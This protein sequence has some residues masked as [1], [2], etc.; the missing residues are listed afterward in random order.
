MKTSLSILSLS[1]HDSCN[2]SAPYAKASAA[3]KCMDIINLSRKLANPLLTPPLSMT[4]QTNVFLSKIPRCHAICFWPLFLL[5]LSKYITQ[6][7]FLGVGCIKSVSQDRLWLTSRR[8][9]YGIF[10]TQ[11]HQSPTTYDRHTSVKWYMWTK[12]SKRNFYVYLIN[13]NVTKWKS[14]ISSSRRFPTCTRLI[15]WVW[16]ADE[17]F[18]LSSSCAHT[19]PKHL[20]LL[21]QF[22]HFDF[23]FFYFPIFHAILSFE[24]ICSLRYIE[25][26]CIFL[27]FVRFLSLYSHFLIFTFSFL[28][29]R[30]PIWW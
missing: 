1:Q 15:D 5:Y 23:T 2:L 14:K 17:E 13:L 12:F 30:Q 11:F 4:V 26:F 18:A 20:S 7:L 29:F 9:V 21:L 8:H 16:S 24:D 22:V 27:R 6:F 3:E 10:S 19:L 25:P 28:S